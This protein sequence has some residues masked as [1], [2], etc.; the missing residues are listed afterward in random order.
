MAFAAY[1]PKGRQSIVAV[2]AHLV[3]R[4]A[5]QHRDQV[6]R[7]EPLPRAQSG[8]EGL[9]SNHRAVGRLD[10]CEATVT[11]AAWV[12]G[13][14]EIAEKRLA[15]AAGRLSQCQQRVQPLM[16]HPLSHVRPV[17]IVDHP[18]AEVDIVHPK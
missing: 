14:T 10:G 11:V 7:A 5:A 13:L 12:A 8:G 3:R 15:S 9:L 16:F 2:L 17:G 4:F 6:F 1:N 18:T